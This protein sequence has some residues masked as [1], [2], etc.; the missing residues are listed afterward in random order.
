M[1]TKC[2]EKL[3]K[4]I[5][6]VDREDIET[7]YRQHLETKSEYEAAISALTDYHKSLFDQTNEF[8]NQLGLRRVEYLPP[9]V[10]ATKGDTESAS[11]TKTH[12]LS[13]TQV[14]FS[15]KQAKPFEKF[16][17]DVIDPADVADTSVLPEYAKDGIHEIEPHITVKYGLHTN[18]HE[19][20]IP[21]LKGEKPIE[22]ELGKTSVFKGSE[23]K[24]PGT[25]KP[26]P[27]DVVT[28][29]VKSPDLERLNK[30][31][32]EGQENTTTF[33]YS[34]HVTLAYVKPG[35]GEKYANRT[36]FEGQKYTFDGVTF[37]PADKSGKSVI[38]LDEAG[39][40][41]K[42]DFYHM[43]RPAI[44]LAKQG[45]KTKIQYLDKGKE[46]PTVPNVELA[47]QNVRIMPKQEP[48]RSKDFKILS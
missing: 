15:P 42:P 7:S 44:E 46:T 47:K 25:D 22:I 24:I 19:D 36:D 18:N 34:P 20:V 11:K 21:S 39:P 13:N 5:S 3:G 4:Q 17:K 41:S 28:V 35:M 45:G 48:K 40:K 27:Y 2:L 32:T 1:L 29:A 9:D 12:P 33:P 26:I 6:S 31:L 8:R 23:K 30:K 37:S 38:P 10:S 43:G 14:E 16:R